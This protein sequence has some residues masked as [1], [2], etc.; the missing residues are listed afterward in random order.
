M[1]LNYSSSVFTLLFLF[2]LIPAQAADAQQTLK[3]AYA[4]DFL[5]GMAV[6]IDQ[7]SGKDPRAADI[8]IRQCSAITP[9]N[10]LKWQAVHP[11]PGTYSFADADRYVAFGA[12]HGMQIIGHVLVW[13]NQTPDWVF[14]DK[15]GKPVS[16]D[17]LLARMKQHIFTVMGRYKGRIQRWDVV[18]EAFLDDGSYRPSPWYKI[19]GPDYIE[20]AFR[21]A[22]EAD[23]D[24][25]LTYNDYNMVIP[26]KRDA[27]IRMVKKLKADGVQIDTVGMQG[28]Y[29][30]TWPS[31]ADLEASVTAY[32]AAGVLVAISELD[33]DVLPQA[34][35]K[36]TA[37]I[38]EHLAE[39][40]NARLN[41]YQKG[42]PPTMQAKLA[43][44]YAAIFAL[45]VKH[46]DIVSRITLW[47]VTDAQSWRNDWPIKGRTS[48]P[49]LFDR[50]GQ[51]KPA[52]FAVLK[53]ATPQH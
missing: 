22:H 15:S 34:S 5:I 47:G 7:V 10:L 1:R 30:L 38:T 27:V 26:A 21:F 29:D 8:V 53:A 49:L 46:R 45:A 17:E 18:N 16:R 52:F 6:N 41:P 23:P 32:G 31:V 25:R 40:G 4:R 37:D 36:K 14:Q 28:H 13:H 11:A 42:L 9:E 35:D 33:L 2:L 51:P 3:S 39:E 19:I 50:A 20:Q 24:A 44:R 12:A 43:E 48:Y